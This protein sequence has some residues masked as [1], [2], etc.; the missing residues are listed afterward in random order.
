MMRIKSHVSQCLGSEEM[1]MVSGYCLYPL[2]IIT[3]DSY[4]IFIIAT[5][6]SNLCCRWLFKAIITL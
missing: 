5:A 2:T 3:L 6:P 4:L 1:V